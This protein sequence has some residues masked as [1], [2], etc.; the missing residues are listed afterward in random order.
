LRF[1][2]VTL[3]A[4]DATNSRSPPAMCQGGYISLGCV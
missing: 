1:N 2:S 4:D 3:A